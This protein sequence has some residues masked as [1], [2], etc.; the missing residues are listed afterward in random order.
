MRQSSSSKRIERLLDVEFRLGQ[1]AAG[2]VLEEGLGRPVYVLDLYHHEAPLRKPSKKRDS[3][4]QRLLPFVGALSESLQTNDRLRVV[5]YLDGET[6]EELAGNESQT[7]GRLRES[8]AS[9]RL[10][11]VAGA[12]TKGTGEAFSGESF[13]RQLFYG[14]LAARHA[15][16]AQAESYLTAEALLFP[17]LPQLV[18]SFGLRRVVVLLDGISARPPEDRRTPIL[19]RGPDGTHVATALAPRVDAALATK[20]EKKREHPDPFLWSNE[21]L[22]RFRQETP[23]TSHPLLCRVQGIDSWR[24]RFSGW[25]T[26]AA[27]SDIHLVTPRQYF[28]VAESPAVAE[29]TS[30]V[31][32]PGRWELG[33]RRQ[34]E[35]V[36]AEMSLLLAERLDALAYAMG[37]G[38]DERELE[39]AWKGLLR[40]QSRGFPG[41]AEAS[42]AGRAIAQSAARY[43]ASH[44]NSDGVE[45]RSLVVFNPSS[46]PREEYLEARLGGEGYRI[47]QGEEEVPSQVVERR[48]GYVTLGFVVQVPALGYRLLEVR[49]AL[50]QQAPAQKRA[51]DSR[52]FTNA[53]YVA[54]IGEGGALSIEA[55]GERLSAAAGHLTVWK[56]KRLHDSRGSVKAIIP[57]RQGPVFDRYLVEGRIAGMP[58]RQR[59]TF[60]HALPRID[61]RTEV[62]FGRGAVFGPELRDWRL[63][64]GEEAK[65]L[66]LNLHSPLT[67]FFADSP[68]LLAD[69][70]GERAHALSV[71]G[72]DD[73]RE[74]GVALLNR[75]SRS[76]HFD[77]T[78]G[79]LRNALAWAPKSTSFDGTVKGTGV[80]ECA[81]LPFGSRLEATR[82]AL[83]YQ[84]PCLGAFV[85]PHA[86]GLPP[87]GSFL[88]VAPPE[89]LL[90]AMFVRDGSV[91]VRLWNASPATAEA[92]VESGASLSLQRCTLDLVRPIVRRRPAD[93]A[94]GRADAA[95]EGKRRR[96][97]LLAAVKVCD[98]RSR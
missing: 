36:N 21:R 97:A 76:H 67:R 35:L 58:F 22:E 78:E 14:L 16:E 77:T 60:Y 6:F 88:S 75:G 91:Y 47:F 89:A 40:A 70:G 59:L 64:A 31:V 13:I 98:F 57:H 56:N 61:L 12:Y 7:V 1:E 18:R 85:T 84:L 54:E 48:R 32:R 53:F 93:A 90:S 96:L 27:R 11:I 37:R 94:L 44:V 50:A 80:W 9:G 42:K 19:L 26:V 38:S 45:G 10:E 63:E 5:L 46:W 74:R 69:V 39:H 4:A 28:E 62:G 68:F 49:P 2:T 55:G 51:L 20:R 52:F 92:R 30:P 33:G 83:D 15:V 3:A 8:L 72:L 29:S 95:A 24:G 82:A 81:L 87:E 79:I 65:M 25:S 34:R 71:A 43:L 86:G 17:Q 23:L 73:E 66:S 41:P